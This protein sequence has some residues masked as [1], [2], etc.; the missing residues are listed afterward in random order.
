MTTDLQTG[1][2]D[3]HAFSTGLVRAGETLYGHIPPAPDEGWFSPTY[4]VKL[5]ALSL[6]MTL[7]APGSARFVTEFIFPK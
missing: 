4:G 1:E 6:S 3:G 2:T 5:P 7:S